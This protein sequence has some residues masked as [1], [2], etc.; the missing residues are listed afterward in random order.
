[1]QVKEI[2]SKNL[3]S[4]RPDEHVS[5]A[6]SKMEKH[7]IHQLP[8]MND[9]RLYGMLELKKLVSRN[10]DIASAKV[11][12]FATNVPQIDA[13]ASVE[14][15]AQL[16][17]SSA[18]R[19]VPVT[20]GGN[21]VGIV[22]ESDIMKVAKQF[23]Q[24]LDEPVEKIASSAECVE[25]GGNY[26]QIK[27]LVLDKNL[28]RV[29]I[30]DANR[31]LGVVSTFEMIK[32]LRGN[33]TMET[34]GR[35]EKVAKEKI[36]LE[37]TPATAVMRPALVVQ[38]NKTIGDAIDLLRTNEEIIISNGGIKI[39]THKDVME[40]FSKAP[41]NGVYVQITGMHDESIEF[42]AKI[43][44]T[45][46]EFVKKMSKVVKN[47]EYLVIHVEKMHKQG[48]KEKYS[49][50]ARFKSHEGFF[51]AHAWGW[52]PIDVIQEVFDNLE[53]EALHKH[54]KIK[55]GVKKSRFLRKGR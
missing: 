14:S 1:M 15:A 51:V 9:G 13:N 41:Q 48:P 44:M 50:R 19:A 39:V 36:R 42:K 49:I 32:I 55:S 21:V 52:K 54:G 22:S 7:R 17:L 37:E 23:V 30:V 25:K 31:I 40:L 43:D 35:N 47:I 20:D 18:F 29:P 45:V 2:M 53:R 26:G 27:N 6:I 11:E 16:L 34:R 28:S 33:E 12:N 46:T 8:V 10:I 4:V 3:I 38:G 5:Q 24:G